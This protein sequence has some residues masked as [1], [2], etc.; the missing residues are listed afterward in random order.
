MVALIALF[1]FCI[2]N[3][4]TFNF[5]LYRCYKQ[6]VLHIQY[7]LCKRIA[8][9]WNA[10]LSLTLV[11]SRLNCNSPS[12]PNAVHFSDTY[13][14]QQAL[15]KAQMP[16]FF[17]LYFP[18]ASKSLVARNPSGS[19]VSE[20]SAGG[21]NVRSPDWCRNVFWAPG[22]LKPQLHC[23]TSLSCEEVKA[24]QGS[25]WAVVRKKYNSIFPDS[26]ES[27]KEMFI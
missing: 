26:Y 21:Q 2:I 20:L 18:Q 1:I 3:F 13:W 9:F 22:S 4:F 14:L 24:A 15:H 8:V 25:S 5:W 11:R 27:E 12:K 10:Q 23:S 16:V 19:A 7:C 17:H 6:W